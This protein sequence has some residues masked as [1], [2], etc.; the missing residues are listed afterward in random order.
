MAYFESENPLID[1]RAVF[2]FCFIFNTPHRWLDLSVHKGIITSESEKDSVFN[3]S[4]TPSAWQLPG[5][6]S[7]RSEGRNI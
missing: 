3:A 4:F 5:L 6:D 7:S 1:W 2:V